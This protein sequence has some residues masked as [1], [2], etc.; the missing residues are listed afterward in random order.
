[1]M[2]QFEW[3]DRTKFKNKYIKPLIKLKLLNMTIPDK[4]SSSRQ[5]YITTQKGM[6]VLEKAKQIWV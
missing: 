1:M 6:K 4:P 2:A 5:K 3:K